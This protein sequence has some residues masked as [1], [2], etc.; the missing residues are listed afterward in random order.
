ML[1]PWGS[2]RPQVPR[3]LA[4]VRIQA[5]WG[6]PEPVSRSPGRFPVASREHVE[7]EIMFRDPGFPLGFVYRTLNDSHNPFVL[8]TRTELT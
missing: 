6:T 4:V 2:Q 5:E 7:L 8:I 1:D 3:R